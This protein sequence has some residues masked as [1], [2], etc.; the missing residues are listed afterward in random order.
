M[1][2]AIVAGQFYP[3]KKEELQKQ[4]ESC[5]NNKFG[6]G[7]ILKLNEGASSEKSDIKKINKKIK[8]LIS[9]H[10]GYI[11]SG[12]CASHGF[13]ELLKI[14]KEYLPTTFV[15]LGPNHSG[16]ANSSFSLSLED[17]ETPLGIVKNN[18]EFGKKL[19]E[20]CKSEGLIQDELAHKH[21]H[22]LEVQ[23]P[24][25]QYIYKLKKAD[26]QIVPIVISA[27]KYE[28]CINLA[29]SI[30]EFFKKVNEKSKERICI[31]A[32]SDFTHFG[33]S[34]GFKPFSKN[35]QENLYSLDNKAI[36]E[37]LQFNSKEFYEKAMETT[38]CGTFGIII[39]IEILK[40]LDVKKSKLLKYYTSGDIIHDYDSAVGYAS[41]VFN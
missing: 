33:E 39:L 36:D 31:I 9:P 15:L 1:R 23:L 40:K 17:F 11:F 27:N 24:F 16:Y 3:A 8:G 4:I 37:I 32:S 20:K 38:I 30:S 5:F 7:D 25:L 28:D 26:F 10:A 12:A 19:L 18:K 21:E 22:S 14:K 2:K 34:Y 35:I 6:P 29:E 41:V 13:A